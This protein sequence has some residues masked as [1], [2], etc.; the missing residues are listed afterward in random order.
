MLQ[1]F[2]GTGSRAEL[3]YVVFDLL[4]LDGDDLT[5]VPLEARKAKLEQLLASVPPAGLKTKCLGREEFVIV[6]WT[7]S[8]ASSSRRRE[9]GAL[10][11]ATRDSA[12]GDLRYAGKVGTGFSM[13][14]LA[15]LRKALTPLARKASPLSATRSGP[16][17]PKDIQWVRPA[18]VAEIAFTE[19]TRDGRIR[20]PSF[21]GLRRDKPAADVVVERPSATGEPSQLAKRVADLSRTV[22]L[23]HLDK[24]LFREARATKAALL[25]HYSIVADWML[26]W[27]VDR[28]LT[29]LRCP[30]GAHAECFFQKHAAKGT[31]ASLARV[32][33]DP[34]DLQSWV[35][36]TG[37][38]GLHVVVP[39]AA[40][41]AWPEAKL[42]CK[43]VAEAF[44]ARAPKRFTTTASKVARKGKIFVDWLRN[45]RGA[46]AI[47]PSPRARRAAP[48][49]LRP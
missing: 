13:A 42:C 17:P 2:V 33:V 47:A 14:S 23:T 43:R 45:A 28:P 35:K 15:E 38:K 12:S 18:L 24:V 22:R 27:L 37:G 30:D 9:F 5:S 46:T 49:S 7:P 25:A 20:H 19:R 40:R 16:K 48:S 6:G 39:I 34:E 11:L 44:A 21:Q 41:V 10:A 3:A 29:L 36:T 8:H 4:H 26:H 31:P 1:N 32:T